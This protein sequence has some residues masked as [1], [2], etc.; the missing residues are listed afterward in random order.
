[1]LLG[2]PSA[3][4]LVRFKHSNTQKLVRNCLVNVANVE[5]LPMP[6]LPIANWGWEVEDWGS[7]LLSPLLEASAFREYPA[8]SFFNVTRM[9][10]CDQFKL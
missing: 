3:W 5:M 2:V 8:R 9:L 6:M 1:M 7:I 4:C 10:F